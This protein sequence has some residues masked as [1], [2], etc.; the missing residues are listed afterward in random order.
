MGAQKRMRD[1][2]KASAN[3]NSKTN[4][5]A[6]TKNK[7]AKT[8]P[9]VVNLHP[10]QQEKIDMAK[11]LLEKNKSA[12]LAMQT[13]TGKTTSI[14]LLMLSCSVVEQKKIPALN[15]CAFPSLSLIDEAKKKIGFTIVPFHGK[16]TLELGRHLCN[17]V[18]GAVISI[19][20]T[21]TWLR[22]MLKSKEKKS[23]G[24][25]SLIKFLQCINCPALRLFI[26]EAH[27]LSGNGIWATKLH[28][29]KETFDLSIVLAS[30]TPELDK[31]KYKSNVM[32]MLS[33]PSAPKLKV[34]EAIVECTDTEKA[35]LVAALCKLPLPQS[36][37]IEL[38][39]PLSKSD[40]SKQLGDELNDMTTPHHRQHAVPRA[41]ERRAEDEACPNP[42]LQ[43]DGEPRRER[44]READ[45]SRRQ[46]GVR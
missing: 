37:T 28:E 31:A 29:I 33:F 8:M 42:R 15:I 22:E 26:D 14:G 35:T 45:A 9:E 23:G 16:L 13:G 39:S 10:I 32:S 46:R 3:K 1:A 20:V 19:A 5:E 17:A 34:E 36:E 6:A 12:Y 11:G 27:K 38:K 2:K 40:I 21:H 25:P 18:D 41:A 7:T 4:G 44:S 30:A 24:Q 43:G